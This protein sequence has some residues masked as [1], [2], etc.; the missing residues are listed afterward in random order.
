[1]SSGI[2]SLDRLL[3][4]GLPKGRIIEVYGEPG[5]GKTT[6]A[7]HA[8][9]EVQRSGGLAVFLDVEHALDPVLAE[10]IGVDVKSMRKY[11]LIH[12]PDYAEQ[13]LGIIETYLDH[14]FVDLIVL[15]SVAALIPKKQWEAD[16]DSSQGYSELPKIMSLALRKFT[17]KAAKA[18]CTIVLINQLRVTNMSGYGNPKEFLNIFKQGISREYD[19]L[20]LAEQDGLV[21]RKGAWI[22]YGEEKLGQGEAKAL[23]RLLEDAELRAKLELELQVSV[24]SRTTTTTPAN[25]TTTPTTLTTT[26]ATTTTTNTTITTTRTTTTNKN[27]NKSEATIG[28]EAPRRLVTVG[29]HRQQHREWHG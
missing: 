15:D 1:M 19:L 20:T 22:Y 4:G 14:G 5:T 7:L 13:A 10:G 26:T 24:S 8:M 11:N 17:Q 16:I 9:A 2:L 18:K 12:Q 28:E 25:A 3:G 27:N 21:K 29:L 23:S 6:V